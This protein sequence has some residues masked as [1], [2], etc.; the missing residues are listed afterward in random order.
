MKTDWITKCLLVVAG[1]GIWALALHNSTPVSAQ[2]PAA[3]DNITAHEFT[4]VNDQGNP[5]AVL[6]YAPNKGPVLVMSDDNRTPQV[7]LGYASG[8]KNG[9]YL[10]MFA[11]NGRRTVNIYSNS[12]LQEIDI[13]DP[14]GNHEAM[15]GL[16][17]K[18]GE[19]MFISR[20]N[21]K[22]SAGIDMHGALTEFYT[23]DA[24]N[25]Y[26]EL[27]EDDNGPFMALKN[28][29]SKYKLKMRA[30]NSATMKFIDPT[31]KTSGEISTDRTGTG[32]LFSD[33]SGMPR[34]SI[35]VL[36]D[37]P[38]LSLMD[39]SGVSRVRLEEGKFGPDVSVYDK[40][41]H[42]RAVLGVTDMEDKKTGAKTP[43]KPSTLTLYDAQRNILF[44]KP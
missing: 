18:V 34:E 2:T 21:G 4:L 40:D 15:L 1:S 9:P 16:Y 14:M 38:Y 17:G 10:T 12:H 29:L 43:S 20:K 33:S 30:S 22:V 7:A 5:V 32:M 36:S 42:P 24:D 8:D 13:H 26:S 23:D 35:G 25:N 44:Q 6:A 37:G 39:A 3:A 28:N 11:P 41:E 27:G 31:G 19:G